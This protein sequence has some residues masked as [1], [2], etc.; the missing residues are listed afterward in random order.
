[1]NILIINLI[2]QLNSAFKSKTTII[3]HKFNKVSLNFIYILNKVGLFFKMEIK[4]KLIILY[5]KPNK[6]NLQNV[7]KIKLLSKPSK[8]KYLTV[9]K[10]KAACNKYK[11]DTFILSTKKGFITH[12]EA[13]NHN[14]GGEIICKI[15]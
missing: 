3:I 4:D 5:L 13:L 2:I 14:L 15:R 7:L 8:K 10:L 6:I 9:Y 12:F 1:M 11:S